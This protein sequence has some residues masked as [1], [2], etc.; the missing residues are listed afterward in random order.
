MLHP[1]TPL[2]TILTYTASRGQEG[3]GRSRAAPPLTN[4][5]RG[6]LQPSL[7]AAILADSFDHFYFIIEQVL[8]NTPDPIIGATVLKGIGMQYTG[9]LDA[10][11]E[12]SERSRI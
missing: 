5:F 7:E 11:Q 6:H 3:T 12:G 8:E 4:V 9:P 10:N 2:F 1:P